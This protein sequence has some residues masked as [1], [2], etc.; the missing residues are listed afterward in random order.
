M[1]DA[2]SVEVDADALIGM[3]LDLLHLETNRHFYLSFNFTIGSVRVNL[4]KTA[5]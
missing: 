1:T 4:V 2:F 5:I 3:D